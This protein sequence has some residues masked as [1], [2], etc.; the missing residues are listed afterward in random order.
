M[1]KKMLATI[2]AAM[3]VM[4]GC[5]DSF[6]ELSDEEAEAIGEYAA[7]T[8]LKYDANSRSRL[9]DLAEETSSSKESIETEQQP[10]AEAPPE[11]EENV[12]EQESEQPK[13]EETVPTVDISESQQS[14]DSMEQFLELPENVSVSYIGYDCLQ[15]YQEKDNS[16]FVVEAAAGKTLLVL[17]FA[18]TNQT[19]A[20]QEI[21][22]LARGD[23]YHVTVNG[24]Y[25]RSALPTMLSN[26]MLTYK[27]TLGAGITKE[28][29]L[30]IEVEE[31]YASTIQ[32]ISLN[33]KNESK[34]YTIHL[35]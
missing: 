4:S 2:C 27:E 31:A 5:G 17:K 34:T 28:T 21:N 14:A 20:S 32:N 35:F 22:L 25:T 6:P 26:D 19:S 33:L 15:T 30:L 18:I 24:E 23:A 11:S 8:L 13:Q 29:V 3:L 16:Y 1:K 12:L 9:V 7:I 10:E